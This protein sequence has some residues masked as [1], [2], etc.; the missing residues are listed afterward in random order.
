[1]STAT[2]SDDELLAS[3]EPGSFAVFYRRHV[4]DLVAFFMRR[5]RSAELAADLT[6]E[7]FAAALIARAR[8][9]AGRA[10][11]SAW[12][13]G[14]ALNKLAR[15]ERREVAERRARRRLGMEWI[16]LTDADIERIDALGSGERARVL[17]ER[18]SP[19]QR[20]SIRVHVIDE[21]RPG[22][23]PPANGTTRMSDDFFIRLERQLE[24]AELRELNRA[25]ALRRI[26]SARP[27]LSVPFAAAAAVGVVVVVIAVLGAIDKNDADRRPQPVGTEP[28]P[29]E[30]VD[31][32]TD[33]GWDVERGMRFGFDGRVLTV[34]LLPPVRN[35]TFET[36]SGARISATCGANVAPPPGD[37]RRETTLTRRWPDGQTSL[38]YRFPR[39]VSSWCR[40]GRQSVGI[41][42]SVSF[43]VA[44]SGAR[45]QIA[46][47][48]NNWAR[49]FASTEQACNA[50]TASS[51]CKQIGC[52]LVGGKPTE[53]CKAWLLPASSTPS[54][55]GWAWEHRGA[56]VQRIA[57]SGDRAAATLSKDGVEIDTVQLRRTATGEWLIDRLGQI[58]ALGSAG[59]LPCVHRR[60][61]CG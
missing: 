22:R 33:V 48:A 17:V 46:E 40:L 1:V 49:V 12:L 61:S 29:S 45:E 52:Q 35:H 24:A 14:I 15:V 16:E 5:T 8:I 6:A 26:V 41:V 57:I 2:E 34:Q 11:A 13:F 51:V 3:L 58:G 25:P 28:A 47:T 9:D 18:F 30:K 20:D 54:G 10:S 50:Y 7:T 37:P 38:S 55:K 27:L 42:A 44:W 60:A 59:L 39:D 56:K 53:A 43:P 23:Q 19:E 36:V 4:E 21:P 31:V 32:V